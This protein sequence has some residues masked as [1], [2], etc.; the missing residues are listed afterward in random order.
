MA[1]TACAAILAATAC[2]GGK[3]KTAENAVTEVPKVYFIKDITSENIMKLYNALGRKA[4]GKHARHS[5]RN[6]LFHNISSLI[7]TSAE[8]V[9]RTIPAVLHICTARQPCALVR[10]RG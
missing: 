2:G 6:Q 8:Q 7:Y 10:R 4:E 3:A 9:L 5:K 1:L